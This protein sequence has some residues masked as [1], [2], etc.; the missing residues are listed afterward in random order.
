MFCNPKKA[1][2]EKGRGR[3]KSRQQKQPEEGGY[4]ATAEL[5]ADGRCR[6]TPPAPRWRRS[7]KLCACY[8]R[9]ITDEDEESEDE[10]VMQPIYIYLQGLW[11]SQ[12]VAAPV[13][14]SHDRSCY[15]SC[16]HTTR[17]TTGREVA[18][19]VARPVVRLESATIIHDRTRP[20]ATD[21]TTVVW[22]CETCVRPPTIWDRRNKFLTCSKTSSR[23][24]LIVRL[25]TTTTTSCTIYL[26]SSA[27]C[28][29]DWFYIGCSL[30]ARPVWP[31]P[32]YN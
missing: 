30:V 15:L 21:R 20:L 12:L 24:I 25:S 22:L 29:L 7:I 32:Y 5:T 27:I 23:L 14:R 9:S 3:G 16:N 17:R 13:L 2:R 28:L 6:N 10:A 19:L 11:K 1:Y 31:G 4:R 8:R 26:R 18:R